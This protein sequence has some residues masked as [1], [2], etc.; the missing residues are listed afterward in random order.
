MLIYKA[1]VVE[2]IL[3]NWNNAHNFLLNSNLNWIY[4]FIYKL[5]LLFLN[6]EEKKILF[7]MGD[8]RIKYLSE[9]LSNNSCKKILDLLSE[10]ELTE[11]DIAKELRIPLNTIDYNIKKLIKAGLIEKTS[12][13]W[14]I[15]GKKMPVYRVSNKTIIISPKNPVNLKTFFGSVVGT[16]IVALV[17]KK[18]SSTQSL[19]ENFIP[20]MEDSFLQ[21]TTELTPGSIQPGFASWQWFLLGAWAGIL[22]FLIFTIINERRIKK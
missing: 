14:S 1:Y 16:G 9:A 18:L 21:K 17:I 13:F 20:R 3:S 10:K 5:V 12:H 19:Q 22:L 7:S 15:R 4:R 2:D 6:M 8:E 11:T